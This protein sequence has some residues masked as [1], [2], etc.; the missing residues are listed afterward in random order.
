MINRVLYQP[1]PIDSINEK[2]VIIRKS[3]DR[4]DAILN[5]CQGY[6]GDSLNEKTL[7]D[8][9]CGHGYFVNFFSSKC[10]SVDGINISDKE[11]NMSKMFY[12][13]IA[14]KIKNGDVFI[15]LYF[16]E[17]HDITLFM[18]VFHTILAAHSE[19]Q[20]INLLKLI[21]EKTKS[22]MFFEMRQ[23]GEEFWVI[24]EQV[25]LDTVTLPFRYFSDGWTPETIK[26]YILEHTSF[27]ECE[28]LMV[29]SDS[30]GFYEGNFERTLFAFYRKK[31]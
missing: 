12:P 25:G 29:D 21:D 23:D 19:E 4:A 15:D 24:P 22:V 18:N 1:S 7:L 26:N 9:G 2:S 30:V 11:V 10:A 27:D 5:F 31:S 17:E 8:I 16:F 28:E 3:T 13:E 14:N 20:A 6:F